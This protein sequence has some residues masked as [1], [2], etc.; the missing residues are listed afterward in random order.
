MVSLV[1]VAPKARNVAEA[2]N[3]IETHPTSKEGL[4]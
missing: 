4:V 2:R 1:C 3:V